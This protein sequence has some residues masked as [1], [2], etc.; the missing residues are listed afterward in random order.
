MSAFE[1]VEWEFDIDSQ[2]HFTHNHNTK[3]FEIEYDQ[4]DSDEKAHRDYDSDD[5]TGIVDADKSNT[6]NGLPSSVSRDR[7]GDDDESTEEDYEVIRIGLDIGGVLSDCGDKAPNL[8][9]VPDALE[10]IDTLY[11]HHRNGYHAEANAE[12]KKRKYKLYIIS[13][14]SEKRSGTRYNKIIANGHGHYFVEQYYVSDRSCK[15]FVLQHVDCHIMIDDKESILDDI[16]KYDANL[17]TI[18]FQQY[19]EQKKTRHRRHL[20][21][22]SW[23]DVMTLLE[24]IELPALK[25]KNNGVKFNIEDM[26]DV[27]KLGTDCWFF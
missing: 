13:Y 21:A 22:N 26:F 15:K 14:S 7:D 12:K 16:K 27:K 8:I 17:I 19:N 18:L 5:D 24:T 10:S 6:N 9:D 23:K 2:Q 4:E 11:N 3:D 1:K 25:T 20:L